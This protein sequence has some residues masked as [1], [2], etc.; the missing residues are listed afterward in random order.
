M[1]G[2]SRTKVFYTTSSTELDSCNRVSIRPSLR[3]SQ[4]AEKQD[5]PEKLTFTVILILVVG[6][7]SDAVT[8]LRPR[9]RGAIAACEDFRTG[10]DFR[11]QGR[12]R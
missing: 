3:I 10:C 8:A 11:R 1:Q 4:L 9:V 6:T 2:V 7:V 12:Q 5:Q